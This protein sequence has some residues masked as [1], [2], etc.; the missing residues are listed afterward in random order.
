[1]TFSLKKKFNSKMQINPNLT[2]L[3]EA[4]LELSYFLWFTTVGN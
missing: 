1:M 3:G 4:A 2:A